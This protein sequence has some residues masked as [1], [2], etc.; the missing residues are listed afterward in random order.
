[1]IDEDNSA[2]LRVVE[3][4]VFAHGLYFFGFCFTGISEA[5]ESRAKAWPMVP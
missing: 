2:V 1:V 5:P 3:F 4:V